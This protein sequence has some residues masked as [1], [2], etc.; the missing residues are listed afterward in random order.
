MLSGAA[1]VVVPERVG[2][3]L[4]LVPSG[5]RGVAEI[6]AGLGG[7]YAA[8]GGWALA[9]RDPVAQR[10]VGV[11]W[12]GAAAARVASLR[13]DRP[14]TDPAFWAYLGIEVACGTV[15]LATA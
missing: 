3:A 10:A 7:A 14:D 5:G 8:L 1:G 6:R 9:T 2:A 12:L 15:A 4:G 11:A 13:L